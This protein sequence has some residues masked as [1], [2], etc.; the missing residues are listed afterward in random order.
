MILTQGNFKLYA[1]H[2]YNN[3][4]C[5]T[6]EEFE[7]DLFKA[8]VI[9]RLITC[10][11][12]K[13]ETNLKLLVNTA[14]SFFNVFEHHAAVEII[15]F[16]TSTEHETHVNSLL[17]FLKLPTISNKLDEKFFAEISKEYE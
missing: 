14:I 10:Y 17:G 8:S 16:K 12:T 7:S 13:G 15:K 4:Y 6:E 1:A 5:L 11:L 3:P 9:R 2:Y